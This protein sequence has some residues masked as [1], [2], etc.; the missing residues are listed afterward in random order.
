MRE[1]PSIDDDR[2]KVT[3]GPITLTDGEDLTLRIRRIDFLPDEVQDQIQKDCEAQDVEA[4]LISVAND[5]V[6]TP[7]G[8]PVFWIPVIKAARQMLVELGVKWERVAP[9]GMN[10]DKFTAPTKK[11]VDAL[12][13][14]A[15]KPQLSLARREK[16]VALVMLKHVLT[17]DELAKVS[18]LT[19]GQVKAIAEEWQKQSALSLGEFMASENS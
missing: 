19:N 6:E 16:S 3:I 5:L 14:W 15:D 18:T 7:V 2:V 9:N 4:S 11:V 17:E 10:R 13:E 1:I 12:Q 8:T